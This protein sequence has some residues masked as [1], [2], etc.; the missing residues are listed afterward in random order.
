MRRRSNDPGGE[1][2]IH[3]THEASPVDSFNH[4]LHFTLFRLFAV[5]CLLDHLP[6]RCPAF[7]AQAVMIQAAYQV[8][9]QATTGGSSATRQ[10]FSRRGCSPDERAQGDC[11][12]S[13][14]F[15]QRR[16]TPTISSFFSRGSTRSSTRSGRVGRGSG[17]PP[18]V[19]VFIAPRPDI[20][21]SIAEPRPPLSSDA[22]R[23]P[24]LTT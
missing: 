4:C 19:T 5:F 11:G 14:A 10:Y 15:R 18:K 12:W 24:L 21:R 7:V 6:Q 2:R 16:P 9:L 13:P 1:R 22:R 8:D 17:S 20:M 3:D 23:A